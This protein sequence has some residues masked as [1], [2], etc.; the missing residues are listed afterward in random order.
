MQP[1]QSLDADALAQ[2]VVNAWGMNVTAGNAERLSAGFKALFEK[3]CAYRDAKKIA[4]NRRT[5]NALTTQ[6]QLMNKLR[7]RNFWTRIAVSTK[8]STRNRATVPRNVCLHST[9]RQRCLAGNEFP[10]IAVPAATHNR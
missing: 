10:R 4:D 7:G 8:P 5:Y 1:E 3:A 2:E 6:E 9:S